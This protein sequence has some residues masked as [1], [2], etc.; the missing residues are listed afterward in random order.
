MRCRIVN[1]H[2]PQAAARDLL[3]GMDFHGAAVRLDDISAVI[4]NARAKQRRLS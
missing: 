2:H 4:V 1:V 3:V